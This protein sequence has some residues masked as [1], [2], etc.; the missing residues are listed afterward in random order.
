MA[1]SSRA[2][3]GRGSD[4]G[5]DACSLCYI[6]GRGLGIES[7]LNSTNLSQE[8]KFRQKSMRNFKH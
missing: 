1:V 8:I 4:R 5:S 3:T 2:G 6:V 7:W